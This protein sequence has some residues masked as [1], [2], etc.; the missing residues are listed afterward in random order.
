[1]ISGGQELVSF[2]KPVSKNK[3]IW[4]QDGNGKCIDTDVVPMREVLAKLTEIPLAVS[5]RHFSFGTNY[6]CQIDELM[7]TVLQ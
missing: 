5:H 6:A 4:R 3:F 2:M 1:M 7:K